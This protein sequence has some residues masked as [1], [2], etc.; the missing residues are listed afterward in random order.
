MCG[1]CIAVPYWPQTSLVQIRSMP[2]GMF[3]LVQPGSHCT[4]PP[5]TYL[6]RQK[7]L[8]QPCILWKILLNYLVVDFATDLGTPVQSKKLPFL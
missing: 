7:K 5:R 1:K 3:N 8:R 4:T 2:I 6:C